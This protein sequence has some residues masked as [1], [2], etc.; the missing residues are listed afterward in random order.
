MID[1]HSHRLPG[2]DDGSPSCNVSIPVLQR[3]TAQGVTVV[4]CPPHLMAG[5]AIAAPSAGHRK[6]LGQLPAGAPAGRV[7]RVTRIFGR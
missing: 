4:V 6:L 5:Q 1:M 7:R 2:V 3:F